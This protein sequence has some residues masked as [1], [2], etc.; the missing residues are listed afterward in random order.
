MREGEEA[1]TNKNK[2]GEDEKVMMV[3]GEWWMVNG[4]GSVETVIKNRTGWENRI[5]DLDFKNKVG[6]GVEVDIERM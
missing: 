1:E 3:G 5:H 4:R 2:E 6:L